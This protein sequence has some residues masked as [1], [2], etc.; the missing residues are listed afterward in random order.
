MN[1]LIQHGGK[2][3]Q[4]SLKSKPKECN[5]DLKCESMFNMKNDSHNIWIAHITKKKLSKFMSFDIRKAV[6]KRI[7]TSE[8]PYSN[9][10]LTK[11][12]TYIY[13]DLFFV[14]ILLC[15]DCQLMT[16]RNVSRNL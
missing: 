15:W 5:W 11:K 7:D 6:V 4:N 3:A 10:T 9:S 12:Y 14:I 13:N 8:Y 16:Q 2:N 1:N